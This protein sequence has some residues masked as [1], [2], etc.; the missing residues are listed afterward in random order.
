MKKR[1]DRK[2]K[3]GALLMQI[4]GSRARCPHRTRVIRGKPGLRREEALCLLELF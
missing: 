3:V 4:L 2:E 1:K